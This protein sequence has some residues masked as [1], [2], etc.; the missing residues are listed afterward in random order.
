MTVIIT[1]VSHWFSVSVSDRRVTLAASG[2]VHDDQANKV[3]LVRT[4]DAIVTIGYTGSAYVAGI[5]TDEWLARQIVPSL[6]P[7]PPS[8][9]MRRHAIPQRLN[10][11]VARIIVAVRQRS[12]FDRSFHSVEIGVGG[13]RDH[14]GD[15]WPFFV[16][17]NK[18][19]QSSSVSFWA[20]PERPDRNYGK[21]YVW[22]SGGWGQYKRAIFARM[23]TALEKI[24]PAHD[25]SPEGVVDVLRDALLDFSNGEQS[26]GT[27]MMVVMT[28]PSR[29]KVE[30]WSEGERQEWD[31]VAGRIASK[32]S[33]M[34]HTISYS[35]WIIGHQTVAPPMQLVADQQLTLSG[36]PIHLRGGQSGGKTMFL[37][38]QARTPPP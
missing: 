25:H 26:I 27:D 4:E 30:I 28:T 13:C 6:E 5:P 12:R 22:V 14:R 8:L 3:L 31:D 9:S 2:A 18:P 1:Y 16:G 19:K 33:A 34:V 35:P 15:L 7:G 17:I 10:E 24:N 29:R 38:M 37:G 36:Y 32:Y 23:M 11:V 21:F 20:F